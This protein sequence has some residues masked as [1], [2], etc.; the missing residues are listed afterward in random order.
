MHRYGDG[1]LARWL[2]ERP[3]DVLATMLERGLN[4]PPSSSYGR[5]FDAVAAA[6]D[7][8][9][10]A[11]S[12]EG[13]AAIELE[14][15]ASRVAHETAGAYPF[16]LI[17]A[18][19]AAQALQLDPAPMWRALLDDL[20]RGTDRSIVAARFHAGLAE[21]TA[22]L[23][24]RLAADRGA[25]TV[26][27]SGG[28]LQNKTLFEALACR[29]QQGGLEVLAHERVPANDGG[30]ALGQAVVAAARGLAAADGAH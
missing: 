7:L 26:A 8:S 6:L 12:Y 17:E 13:Q 10:A 19:D 22:T 24:A 1:E 4:A 29:L 15:L 20:Q 30:L 28:V 27:L 14:A 5:L 25:D 21:A 9:R 3:L 23:A 11:V 16:G 2:A 18:P